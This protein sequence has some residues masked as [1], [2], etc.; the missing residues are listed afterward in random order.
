MHAMK[1]SAYA[2]LPALVLSA[3]ASRAP[4]VQAPPLVCPK[5]PSP[6]AWAMESPRLMQSFES[7][8]SITEQP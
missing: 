5:P 8:F 6:A 2:L 3:C 7:V 1:T 4:T